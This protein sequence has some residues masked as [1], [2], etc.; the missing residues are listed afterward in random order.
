MN[1][2][3]HTHWTTQDVAAYLG[4]VAQV[5]RYL[6]NQ[7]LLPVVVIHDR[8]WRF[9]PEDV[10]AA[11]MRIGLTMPVPSTEVTFTINT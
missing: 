5:V 11:A 2:S 8:C 10:K 6:V 7:G 1:S 9:V 4:T 3:T